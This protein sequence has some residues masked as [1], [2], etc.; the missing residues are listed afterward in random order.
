MTQQDVVGEAPLGEGDPPEHALGQA[1]CLRRSV[2]TPRFF[3]TRESRGYDY[4]ATTIDGVTKNSMAPIA[5][6]L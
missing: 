2:S 6:L 3:G 1:H 4:A 5:D